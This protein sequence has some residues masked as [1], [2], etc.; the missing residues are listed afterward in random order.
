MTCPDCEKLA[1]RVERLEARVA[2]LERRT[3]N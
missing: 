2:E 1:K 3:K